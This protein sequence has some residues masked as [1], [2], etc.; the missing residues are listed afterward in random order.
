MKT[1]KISQIQFE[2]KPTPQENCNQLEKFYKKALKFKPSG[3]CA[4]NFFHFKEQRV[5][6]LKNELIKFN[7]FKIRK[8]N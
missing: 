2:A 7:Y 4:A 8:D 3:I 5:R 1:L 6:V